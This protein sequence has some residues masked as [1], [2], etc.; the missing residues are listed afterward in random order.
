MHDEAREGPKV[1]S[2]WTLTAANQ[3]AEFMGI[4]PKGRSAM[5]TAISIDVVDGGEIVDHWSEVSLAAFV[6]QLSDA[7]TSYAPLYFSPSCSVQLDHSSGERGQD[8]PRVGHRDVGHVPRPV[9]R[10]NCLASRNR[11][12]CQIAGVERNLKQ[13]KSVW[14]ILDS[15][16]LAYLSIYRLISMPESDVDWGR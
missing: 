14:I 4:P 15:R 11:F 5:A 2:R 6:G 9:N 7:E 13:L 8:G 1:A 12:C 3:K 16:H 10:Q